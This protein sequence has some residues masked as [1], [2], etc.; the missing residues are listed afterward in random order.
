MMIYL[1]GIMEVL[2]Q[3]CEVGIIIP[4]WQKTK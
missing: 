3:S 1:C 4:T 2:Q